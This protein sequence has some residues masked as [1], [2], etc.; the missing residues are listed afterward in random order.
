MDNQISED[1]SIYP[2]I[3]IELFLVSK[4]YNKSNFTFIITDFYHTHI[5]RL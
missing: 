1:F 4:F 3:Y 2:F 5:F